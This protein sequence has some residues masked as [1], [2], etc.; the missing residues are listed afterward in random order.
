MSDSYFGAYASQAVP[1][2][3]FVGL[4]LSLTSTGIATIHGERA[5]VDR[6][7]S[8]PKKDA[9]TADQAER[10]TN[11][12][13]L[14]FDRLPVSEY[15]VIGVEGPSFASQGSAAHILGGLWW[16]VRASLHGH[17]AKVA[18]VPPGTVKKYA[19]GKGNASKDEVLAAVIRRY[20]TVNV[21]NNDEA[22][23]LVIAALVARRQGY[24]VE[25]QMPAK[26]LEAVS[27]VGL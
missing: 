13:H 21:M 5:T 9:T 19:T 11:I 27:G 3:I 18:V 26:N 17:G 22:D 1:V 8:N 4:D 23:A 14:I 20:P 2:P 7:I 16:M 15:T 25:D 24:P 12:L 10:L 6:V